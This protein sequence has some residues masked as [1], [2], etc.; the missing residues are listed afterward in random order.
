[1]A[2]PT[3]TEIRAFLEGYDIT[4][5]YLSDPWIEARRDNF[6]IPQVEKVIRRK[7]EGTESVTEYVSGTGQSILILSRKPINS[8]TSI[9]YVTGGD[10]DSTIGLGGIEVLSEEGIL[11]SVTNITEGGYNIIFAKGEKNIKVT[12]TIG[13]DTIEGDLKEALIYLSAE[14]LLG[15]IGARTG[16]GALTVQ[17]FSRNFGERGKY[18]DIRNDLKRQAFGLLRKYTTGLVGK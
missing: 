8:V 11:K 14:Q 2:K 3:A 12:Y 9:E 6:I 16:G 7:V 13:S 4:T 17:G 15:F 10:Y 1:M 5:S 18:Q